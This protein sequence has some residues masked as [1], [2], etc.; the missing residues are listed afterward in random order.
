MST[1]RLKSKTIRGILWSFTDRIAQQAVGFVISVLLARLLLPAEFGLMAM[2]TVFIAVSQVLI[3]GG[4]GAALIQKKD[5]SFL[6]ECSIF[7]FNI[8]VSILF[9]A[10][11]FLA[12]PLIADFFRMPLLVPMTRL[13]SLNLIISAFGLIQVSLMIRRIDF[14][15]QMIVSLVSAVFSGIVGVTMAMR[16]FGVWSLVWQALLGNLLRVTLLWLVHKWRPAWRFSLY[17]L[18]QMFNF[19]A[20]MLFIGL[21][22]QLFKN[23][24]LV[25]IGKVFSPA[26]LGFYVRAQSI[27]QLPGKDIAIS[28]DLVSFPVFSSIQDDKARMKRGLRQGMMMQALLNIPIMIGLACVAESFV[29]VLLTDKWLPCVPYL[30]VLCLAGLFYPLSV[31]NISALKAQGRS[32]LFFRLEVIK[33]TLAL[34]VIAVTFR[35]GIMALVIGQVIINWLCYYLNSYYTARF[36][37]YSIKEQIVDVLPTLGIAGLMGAGVFFMGL[38]SLSSPTLTLLL[39]VA[40][41]TTLFLTLCLIFR[42]AP[43]MNL[44]RMAENQWAKFKKVDPALS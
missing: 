11:L 13:L 12:A 33:K 19:G 42:L 27:Q 44:L 36:L 43:F 8:V 26:D 14:R 3:N 21:I 20:K 34:I 29:R 9:T 25:V 38:F 18:R 41:G 40:A 17:S 6:D 15:K 30:Q 37:D 24:Y 28:S 10:I 39:Q 35:W 7:Y 22:D 4:F 32:D 31:M 2:L 23:I 1:E 5:A 16:G